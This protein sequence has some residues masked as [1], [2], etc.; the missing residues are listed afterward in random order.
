MA[1]HGDTRARRDPVR[2]RRLL[3]DAAAAAVA[4]HGSGVSLE[5]IARTAGISKSGLAHHYG[6]KDELFTALARDAYERFARGVE[7]HVDPADLT[8]GRVM[9]G[10]IRATFA[11]LEQ[12]AEAPDFWAVESQLAVVPSVA[13]TIRVESESWLDRLSADGFDRG[14][15]QLLLLAATGAEV[16]TIVGLIDSSRAASLREQM[17]RL[18]YTGAALTEAVGEGG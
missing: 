10:Y 6:S 2:T 3:L 7:T 9:R 11:D 16:A 4:E 8:P 13:E 5:V 14:A 15:A 18:T 1:D 17:I 12:E